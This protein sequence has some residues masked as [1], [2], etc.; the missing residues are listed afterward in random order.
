MPTAD[1]LKD[2]GVAE[3]LRG[4]YEMAAETFRQAIAR[5]RGTPAS[6]TWWPRCRS[7]WA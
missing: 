2:K 6:P 7:T 3:Y 5:Y 4:D 1:E